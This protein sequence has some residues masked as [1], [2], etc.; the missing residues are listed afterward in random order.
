M[1]FAV[2]YWKTETMDSVNDKM[3]LNQLCNW[4]SVGIPEEMWWSGPSKHTRKSIGLL[5]LWCNIQILLFLELQPKTFHFPQQCFKEAMC[6]WLLLPTI[7]HFCC[8]LEHYPHLEES[9][10]G[11]EILNL[12][13]LVLSLILV[14]R[15]SHSPSSSYIFCNSPFGP[16]ARGGIGLVGTYPI[17]TGGYKS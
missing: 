6:L 10:K 8:P 9:K 12:L 13:P 7:S 14:L 17:F 16:L 4:V 2:I 3:R 1:P 15:A 11:F 5:N